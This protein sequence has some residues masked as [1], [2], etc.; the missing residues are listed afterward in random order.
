VSTHK[1]EFHKLPIPL[2]R[3]RFVR[4]LLREF[5]D[6]LDKTM[7]SEKAVDFVA[8]IGQRTG[9]Q[10]D[11][12]YRAAL[13]RL[14]L[15]REE[16]AAALV[17]LKRRIEGEF[18]IIEESDEKI[19]LGNRA[20]PFGSKVLDRPSLCMMTSSVFGSI[21]SRNLGYAKVEL[22]ETIARHAKECRVVVYLRP[23]AE[24][25]QAD[26]REFRMSATER[27]YSR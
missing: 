9:G 17:D 22:Q 4:E 27:S 5:A 21:A 19:V 26:G 7:G 25:E 1:L 12:Y 15:S 6:S 10:F 14:N 11:A 13:K 18:Y 8:E 24:A 20:C 16:V 2:D 3:D 23:T